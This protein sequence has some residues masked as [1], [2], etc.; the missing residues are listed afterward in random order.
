MSSLGELQSRFQ[1]DVLAEEDSPGLILAEGG[2]VDGGQELY[3]MAYS[4]RLLSALQDNFPLPKS[5]LGDEC[6]FYT[7]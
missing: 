5:A 6:L 3:L 2:E 7:S 1:Q 4:A